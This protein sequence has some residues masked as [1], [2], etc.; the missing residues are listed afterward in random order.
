VFCPF[1]ALPCVLNALP[2]GNVK[3]VVDSLVMA[4]CKIL[5]SGIEEVCAFDSI[6]LNC[7]NALQHL[8]AL[9]SKAGLKASAKAKSDFAKAVISRVDALGAA[10]DCY[11]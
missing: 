2:Q 7:L 10:Y 4:N 11:S 6:A 5:C 8:H 1:D 3:D 9:G